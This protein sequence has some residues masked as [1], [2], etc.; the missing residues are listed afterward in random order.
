MRF[1]EEFFGVKCD[2]CGGLLDDDNLYPESEIPTIMSCG[3][4]K[5]LGGK[6]Y[7]PDCWGYDDDDNIIT[8]DGRKFDGDDYEEIK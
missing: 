2:C 8:K 5:H 7:C 1:K 3:G 4:W 6:D